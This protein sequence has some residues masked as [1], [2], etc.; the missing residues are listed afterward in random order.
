MRARTQQLWS[1]KSG[2]TAIE[3]ALMAMLFALAAIVGA[4]ALGTQVT[5]MYENQSN[6]MAKAIGD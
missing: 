4:E 5:Q 3:Y 1:N 2:T 6:A